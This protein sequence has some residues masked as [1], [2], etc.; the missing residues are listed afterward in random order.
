MLM[1]NGSLANGTSSHLDNEEEKKDQSQM[2][3][4]NSDKEEKVD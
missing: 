2:Q 4:T 1:L 3:D